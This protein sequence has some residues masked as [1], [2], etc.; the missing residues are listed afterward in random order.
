MYVFV[1]LYCYICM[2]LE[3]FTCAE[4]GEQTAR[5]LRDH[6]VGQTLGKVLGSHSDCT[7]SVGELEAVGDEVAQHL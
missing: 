5:G 6:G 3:G 2:Y 4:V 1:G 7:S